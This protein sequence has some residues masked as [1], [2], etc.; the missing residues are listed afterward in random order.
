MESW[1]PVGYDTFLKRQYGDYMNDNRSRQHG[2]AL[3]DPFTPCNHKEIL[4]WK[5]REI[6]P[7]T[8]GV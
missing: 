8:S 2:I 7:V 4:H 1:I 3:P 6:K 5:N